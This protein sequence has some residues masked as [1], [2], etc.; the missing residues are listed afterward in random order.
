MLVPVASLACVFGPTGAA[1]GGATEPAPWFEPVLAEREC[2]ADYASNATCSTLT[3]AADRS[4]PDSGTL[5]L[6]VAVLRATGPSRQPDAVVIPE[7]GPGYPGFGSV[8]LANTPWNESR[9][10]VV[11][12]QRGTGAA[13]P[14][15][16][17]PAADDAF[18]AA[19][20]AH[21]TYEH[22]RDAVTAARD[23]C[24][25]DLEAQGV[26][27]ADYNSE[28][29][30]AD[31]D[32]L[33]QALGYDQWNLLGISYGGRLTLA[34]MR[35]FPDGVR[36]VILDSVYDVTY[37]GVAS[38][39]ARIDRAFGQLIDGCAA[40][41]V[42][43]TKY[44]DLGADIASVREMYNATPAEVDADVG[45]GVEHFVITGDDMLAGLFNAL[46]DA[47]VIPILPSVVDGLL[48]GETGV[49]PV[50]VERGVPFATGFADVMAFAVNCADNA[51]LDV[52]DADT[53]V[54]D[55]PDGLGLVVGQAGVCPDDWPATPGDFNAPV[56]SDIPALV[57]AGQYDPITPPQGTRRVAD[58]LSNSTFLLVEPVGHG[59]TN[60]N[61]CITAIEL[62]FLDAPDAA[63]DATC[64][65]DIAGPDFQ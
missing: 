59:V 25:A 45:D 12:D 4:D 40:H 23:Q 2:P 26:D 19:L 43:S 36:S 37:G 53:H 21:D 55:N 20:Q 54:Y 34:T 48:R 3:V 65:Q 58:T 15:L 52:I 28:A 6:P 47:T 62:A 41:P 7:G 16:E 56:V 10:I 64:A 8:W 51:D 60:L 50:F 44:G 17:C 5:D 18:V 35:S 1:S 24:I 27:L 32:D 29:S 22:E 42:C 63:V 11:Y 33:R 14:A 46:Y 57:L 61:D 31:L 49:L 38:T 9:D 13:V 39:V 30:A